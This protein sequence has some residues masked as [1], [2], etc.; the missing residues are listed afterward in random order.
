MICASCEG[1]IFPWS[2]P[3]VTNV[4]VSTPGGKTVTLLLCPSCS[5]WRSRPSQRFADK[6]SRLKGGEA[7]E[8]PDGN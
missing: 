4:H 2:M 7:R 3:K 5:G 8:I 6:V 1:K